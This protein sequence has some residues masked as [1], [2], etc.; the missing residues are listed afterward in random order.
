MIELE[1]TRL[2]VGLSEENGAIVSLRDRSNGREYIEPGR[3]G[4][5]VFR[6]ETEAGISGGFRG[7]AYEIRQGE[8]YRECLLRWQSQAGRRLPGRSGCGRMRICWNFAAG[9][10]TPRMD[11]RYQLGVSDPFGSRGDHGRRRGRRCRPQ[12]C[13]GISGPKSAEAFPA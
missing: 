8:G 7:F 13:H 1:N 11:A 3:T 2:Y 5:D 4:G 9:W 6:L 10:R 12:L